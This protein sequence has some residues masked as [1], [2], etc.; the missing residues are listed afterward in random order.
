MSSPR[1]NHFNFSLLE[2]VRTYESELIFDQHLTWKLHVE[3]VINQISPYVNVL[4]KIRYYLDKKTLMNFYYAYINS[5]ITYCLPV[6][7]GMGNELKSLIQRAQNKAI[8]YIN[9]LP[10]VTPTTQLYDENLLKFTDHLVYENIFFIYKVLSGLMKCD[11]KLDTNYS[12]TKR[13]TRQSNLIKTP[14]FI[15]TKAQSSIFYRGVVQYNQF[16]KFLKKNKIA[17]PSTVGM[18]KSQIREFVRCTV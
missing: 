6:W 10:V 8:K 16:I 13:T 5:R 15:T 14:H 1:E 3:H 11:L 18:M 9:F 4:S 2:L 7:Q 17:I 12:C